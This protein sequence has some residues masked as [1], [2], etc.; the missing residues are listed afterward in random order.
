M[1]DPADLPNKDELER[2]QLYLANEKIKLENRK[3]EKES[4][5]ERWWSNIVKNIV[6]VGGVLTVA[7]TAYGLW[8]SYDKTITDR[9][10]ARITEQRNRFEEAIKRLEGTGTISKLVGV[11]VLSGYFTRANKEF[12][13]QLLFTLASL[14]ATEQDVQTQAAVADL[15]S[16][17]PSANIDEDNWLYFQDILASQSRALIAKGSLYEHRQ[18]G[19]DDVAVSPDER[20]A[21]FV[22]KLISINIHSG[23]VRKY[24]NY[25]GIYCEDCDFRGVTFPK[26]VNFTGAV[27]DR[28]DFRDAT[29]EEATFDNADLGGVNFAQAYLHGARFRTIN[30]KNASEKD[31]VKQLVATPYL[32]HIGSL[33]ATH[34]RIVI[35]MPNFSCANLENARFDN[36]ALFAV[37]PMAQR[38]FAKGDDAKAGWPKTVPDF[39]KEKADKSPTQFEVAYVHPVKFFKANLKGAQLGTALYFTIINRGDFPEEFTSSVYKEAAEFDIVQGGI[40]DD[41]L[42]I[43]PE[44]KDSEKKGSQASRSGLVQAQQLFRA[45][46]YQTSL[47]QAVLPDGFGDFLKKL[48]PSQGDYTRAFRG[49]EA[50]LK[51]TPRVAPTP[52]GHLQ[53]PQQN[54]TLI[55]RLLILLG[56]R[57]PVGPDVRDVTPP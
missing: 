39:I 22:G 45:S 7:A 8:D 56:R 9:K 15:V 43:E 18:F 47:D 12:H 34:A 41:V 26:A 30:P 37:L 10:S 57:E 28:A 5:P 50:D 49:S 51:C 14:V 23:V 13:H 55:G 17:I 1:T 3:L 25:A 2:Q 36:N 21:R 29:L 35:T 16:A 42:Q 11:S 52:D 40:E 54:V 31:G 53:Q 33:L 48:P 32:Y 19:M 44:K 20:L 38:T 27:L 4:A 24:L 46:Y 6:A